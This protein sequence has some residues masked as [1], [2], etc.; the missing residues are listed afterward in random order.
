[1]QVKITLQHE[2]VTDLARS[3]VHE[4]TYI[5]VNANI[6]RFLF[7]KDIQYKCPFLCELC[8]CPFV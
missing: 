2:R 3:E 7:K 6:F 4:E 8:K 5:K 1:M